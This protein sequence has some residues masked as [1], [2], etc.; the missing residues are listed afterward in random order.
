VRVWH[1]NCKRE[2]ADDGADKDPCELGKK[3]LTGIRAEQIAALQVGE[4]VGR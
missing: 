1:Q 2:H 3:P 4:Q